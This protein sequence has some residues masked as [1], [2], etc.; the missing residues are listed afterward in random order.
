MRCYACFVKRHV[1]SHCHPH[2]MD[3][4]ALRLTRLDSSTEAFYAN[5]EK[6]HFPSSPS[7]FHVLRKYLVAELS[8]RDKLI[9]EN[10][11][12]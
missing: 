1:F 9:Y 11:K 4:D 3:R 10:A 5:K 12:L 7:V 6:C 8:F 2:N